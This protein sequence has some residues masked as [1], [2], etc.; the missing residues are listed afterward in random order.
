[1]QRLLL[2]Y[3]TLMDPFRRQEYDRRNFI[4]QPELKF[5]YRAFLNSRPEDES[6]QSRLVFFDLLHHREAEALDL[7]DRLMER[8]G[9]SLDLYLDREDYM[10]CAFLLA[11]EYEHGLKFQQAVELLLDIVDFENDQPYFRH[12]FLDVTERLR[13]LVCF[14]MPSQLPANEVIDYLNRLIELDLP[15]KDIAFYLKKSA[16]LYLDI[17]DPVTATAYLQ[18]GLE[19]DE[20]LAGTKKLRDRLALYQ[21]A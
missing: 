19:L 20:K 12:F 16:E 2:A 7:Y 10:D 15:A 9:F 11:E 5:S 6:L 8:E 4:F 18:R 3:Q 13:T 1:M 14:K 21:T 17:G